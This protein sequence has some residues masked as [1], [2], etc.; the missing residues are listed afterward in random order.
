MAAYADQSVFA[1]QL[2]TGWSFRLTQRLEA[3]TE[4][5]YFGTDNIHLDVANFNS[6]VMGNMASNYYDRR[7][8][9]LAHNLFV[10]FRVILR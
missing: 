9:Y 7:F 1:Y 2:I 4:Y 8:R 10:G 5:R 3:F 6:G